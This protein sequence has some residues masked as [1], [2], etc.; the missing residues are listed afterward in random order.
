[1]NG[2]SA[3]YMTLLTAQQ[4]ITGVETYL[5]C[6]DADLATLSY[7]ARR[8]ACRGI[9]MNIDEALH[10]AVTI[11]RDESNCTVGVLTLSGEI[12]ATAY[13]WDMV[14][15]VFYTCPFVTDGGQNVAVR[16]H[17]TAGMYLYTPDNN[18]RFFAEDEE[19]PGELVEFFKPE[20]HTDRYMESIL[21]V[22][23]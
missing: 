23:A 11:A 18:R 6:V 9:T 17:R 15:K 14:R 13:A 7:K 5:V 16:P 20:L 8:Q 3:A 22:H 2:M 4:T 19:F 10:K 12:V 1:M 21:T